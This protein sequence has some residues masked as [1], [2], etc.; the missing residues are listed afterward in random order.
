VFAATS[1]GLLGEHELHLQALRSRLLLPHRL[2]TASPRPTPTP[3]PPAGAASVL[4]DLRGAESAASARLMHELA[5]V[6]P[7]LAQLMASI[8]ASESSHV[9]VLGQ[10]RLG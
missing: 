6:P 8:A 5:H 4:A 10:V 2:A 1:R 7:A 3:T 9:V